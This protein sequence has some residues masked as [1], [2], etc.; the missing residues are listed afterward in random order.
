VVGAIAALDGLDDAS[1]EA[2][3]LWLTKAHAHVV[4]RDAAD[5]VED[6]AL[7]RLRAA[8]RN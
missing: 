5:K 3:A 2:A 7:A 6:M 4:A 1:A 8:G